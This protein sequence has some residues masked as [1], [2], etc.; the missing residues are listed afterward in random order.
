MKKT[1]YVCGDEDYSSNCEISYAGRMVIVEAGS[2]EGLIGIDL[3]SMMELTGDMAEQ[4]IKKGGAK[5]DTVNALEDVVSASRE[6]LRVM[7]RGKVVV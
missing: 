4:F 7:T 3:V 1:V 6:Y 2:D 5:P